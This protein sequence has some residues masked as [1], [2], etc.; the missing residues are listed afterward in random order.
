MYVQLYI[1][2]LLWLLQRGSTFRLGKKC[3]YTC[4]LKYV[5]RLEEECHT[6][7]GKTHRPP[8]GTKLTTS[9]T[10][11]WLELSTCMWSGC[12]PWNCS[13]FECQQRQGNNFYTVFF[14][15]VYLSWEVPV[16]LALWRPWGTLRFPLGPVMKCLLCSGVGHVYITLTYGAPI[17]RHIFK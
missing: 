7:L 8:R 6:P 16:W 2:L 12:A 10:K 4:Q 15:H 5:F 1:F 11:Q 14:L 13:R 17:R 9:L 3:C